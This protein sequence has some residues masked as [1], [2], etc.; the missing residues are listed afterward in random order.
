[1]GPGSVRDQGTCKHQYE[2]TCADTSFARILERVATALA[3]KTE[4]EVI[5]LMPPK[6]SNSR[7]ALP[8]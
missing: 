1:M 4:A 3:R 2:N 6:M 5:S 7:E 8:L